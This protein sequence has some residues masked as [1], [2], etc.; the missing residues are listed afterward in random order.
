MTGT[1]N[2]FLRPRP[3]D[4]PGCETRR[5]IVHTAGRRHPDTLGDHSGFSAEATYT[6]SIPNTMRQ[7]RLV[8]GCNDEIRGLD[9]GLALIRD[10]AA[11]RGNLVLE[12][13]DFRLEFPDS[14]EVHRHFFPQ[15]LEH[16][17]PVAAPFFLRGACG[18]A[19]WLIPQ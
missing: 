11:D 17:M 4:A 1:Q 8:E 19:V 13:V 3:A 6:G 2:S 18:D 5:T 14:A 10:S 15:R 12:R 16:E 7:G 9:D